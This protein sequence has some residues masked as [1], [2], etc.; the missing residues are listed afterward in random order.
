MNEFSRGERSAVCSAAKVPGPCPRLCCEDTC[1][2]RG[3]GTPVP[4][5]ATRGRG[6]VGGAGSQG[7]NVVLVVRRRSAGRRGMLRRGR[8]TPSP[9]LPWFQ[10]D[11]W[12]AL[13]QGFGKSDPSEAIARVGVQGGGGCHQRLTSVSESQSQAVDPDAWFQHLCS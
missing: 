3:V 8:T 4:A 2:R 7:V 11:T 13:R 5:A 12:S 10:Q 9:H 1:V 6:G